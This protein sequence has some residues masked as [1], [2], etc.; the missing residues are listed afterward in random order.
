MTE[1]R[2]PETQPDEPV[3]CRG[4]HR[5]IVKTVIG[6]M[7]VDARGTPTTWLCADNDELAV[8]DLPGQE[9]VCP[10]GPKP[11]APAQRRRPTPIPRRRT[12][13]HEG[14]SQPTAPWPRLDDEPWWE[15]DT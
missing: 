12:V 2:A 13:R 14:G 10:A 5:P 7:H 4:C 8:P 3:P 15:S 9:A 6:W 1:P 11:P